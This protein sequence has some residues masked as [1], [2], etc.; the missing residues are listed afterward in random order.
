MS[1]KHHTHHKKYKAIPETT[2]S[3]APG[4]FFSWVTFTSP[5]TTEGRG[6]VHSTSPQFPQ[7]LP[8]QEDYRKGNSLP[9]L[10]AL[11][12]TLQR[13]RRMI[14]QD[15]SPGHRVRQKRAA[16]RTT[17]MEDFVLEAGEGFGVAGRFPVKH[18]H[19]TEVT[20]RCDRVRK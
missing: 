3:N 19:T 1:N 14:S 2:P 12:T 16:F 17:T 5:F 6:D 20:L 4:R 15:R 13:R 9:A 7:Q 11:Q 10:L 8:G 18:F